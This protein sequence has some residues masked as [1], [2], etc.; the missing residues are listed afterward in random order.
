MTVSPMVPSVNRSGFVAGNQVTL[1]Q[2]GEAFFPAIEQAFDRAR[3]EIYLALSRSKGRSWI[4][5]ANPLSSCGRW[6]PER[7]LVVERTCAQNCRF[8]PAPEDQCMPL[9][10]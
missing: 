3:F 7:P 8:R 4:G 6:W 5:S 10:W 1:L 2:N 9:F